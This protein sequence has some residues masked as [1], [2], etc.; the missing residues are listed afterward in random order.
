MRPSSTALGKGAPLMPP[1]YTGVPGELSSCSLAPLHCVSQASLLINH[2]VLSELIMVT[3][4]PSSTTPG[5][6]APR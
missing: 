5:S 6:R 2:W 1:W 4:S 3:L